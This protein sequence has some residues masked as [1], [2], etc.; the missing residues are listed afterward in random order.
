MNVTTALGL[1]ASRGHK[2]C[3]K[4]LIE[5]GADVN[6]SGMNLII[7]IVCYY[8]FSEC[9]KHIIAAG[10]N[11]NAEGSGGNT[12]LI[13]CADG[14]HIDCVQTLLSTGVLDIHKKNEAGDTALDCAKKSG[15]EVVVKLLESLE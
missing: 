14:G 1:A 13:A 9:L 7:I 10:G 4:L 11:P 15:H 2:D 12:A 8:G 6:A 3:V 5:Y